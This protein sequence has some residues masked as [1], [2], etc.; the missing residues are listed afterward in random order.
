[1]NAL[2][3]LEF[4]INTMRV[5]LNDKM[6]LRDAMANIVGEHTTIENVMELAPERVVA[7]VFAEN[8][9]S[10]MFTRYPSAKP[11]KMS[12]GT[13]TITKVTTTS[14]HKYVA[15]ILAM[16]TPDDPLTNVVS[17]FASALRGLL[18]KKN[19][20]SVA[21]VNERD[22]DLYINGIMET[23]LVHRDVA[24]RVYNIA[25]IPV[26][27]SVANAME[28]TS[29]SDDEPMSYSNTTISEYTEDYAPNGWSEFF[30]SCADEIEEASGIVQRSV[31]E[32][33]TIHP[34]IEYIYRALEDVPI[35]AL[36]VV[37][38]GQDPYHNDGE[39]HGYAFSVPKGVKIPPSLRTIKKELVS[40]GFTASNSGNLRRWAKQGVLLLNTALTVVHNSPNSHKTAWEPFT[41]AIVRY[42]NRTVPHCVF[43]LWGANAGKYRSYIGKTH[44]VI[45]GGHPSPLN[46][47]VPFLGTEP[48]SKTNAA[49][50]LYGMEPID[51]SI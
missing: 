3:V 17:L 32:G 1:M 6:R 15:N 41:N 27:E 18:N 19:I 50:E 16:K 7:H 8:A 20:K 25:K 47:T 29:E 11:K 22:D 51:W 33:N 5:E 34:P 12:L 44:T 9:E 24:F 42:I 28:T 4:D 35:K 36:H 30:A 21:F 14:G 31:D 48:F 46:T 13:T 40:D 39:A 2:H 10:S 37:I 26:E 23:M 43:I 45:T 49:L 38:I